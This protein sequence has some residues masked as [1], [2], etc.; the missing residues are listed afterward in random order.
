MIDPP[1][2]ESPAARAADW[3]V[4]GALAFSGLL[5]GIGRPLLGLEAGENLRILETVLALSCLLCAWLVFRVRRMGRKLRA[6]EEVMADVRFGPGTKRD[7]EA[8]DI[9]VQALRVSDEGARTTALRTLKKISGIDLGEDA[10]AWEE[11]WSVA[12]STFVRPGPQPG[13]QPGALQ[14][15]RPGPKK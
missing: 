10:A 8:V 11:W 7:R 2:I 15:Q 14:G 1:D 9:L 12:R 4:A 6:M 3:L 5:A 13:P